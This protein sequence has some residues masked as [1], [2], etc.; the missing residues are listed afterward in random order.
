MRSGVALVVGAWLA[1]SGTTTVGQS[2]AGPLIPDQNARRPP[3]SSPN[4]LTPEQILKAI[5]TFPP[6]PAVAAEKPAGEAELVP[7]GETLPPPDPFTMPAAGP[8]RNDLVIPATP[9]DPEKVIIKE[10]EGQVSLMVREGSL[11]QVVS[12]VAKTQRLNIVF[13]GNSD[14][15]V[16]ASFDLQPWQVVLDSLLSASG[17]SW[18][19]RDDVIFI[20]SP[21]TANFLPPGAAGRTVMV[22]ELDFASAADIVHRTP[23]GPSARH[24]APLRRSRVPARASATRL[25][26]R[27]VN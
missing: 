16:T 15:L 6:A 17:H 9:G 5:G 20:S 7:E 3:M 27:H 10:S 4:V 23:R 21:Q 22:Y 12:M 19:T 18:T 11:R 13:A 2:P 14:T 24:G 1:L 8:A 26:R 25:C